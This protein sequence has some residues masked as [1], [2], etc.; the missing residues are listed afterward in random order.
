MVLAGIVINLL[1]SYLKGQI[2]RTVISTTTWWREK[3]VARQKAWEERIERL[4]K[5]EDARE[6]TKH[7]EIVQRLQSIHLLLLAMFMLILPL[8][9][10]ISNAPL[11]RVLRITIFGLSALIFFGSFL[12]FR[13]AATTRN[14]LREALTRN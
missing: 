7:L 3:S 1:S 10:S 4:R 12:V 6:F 2:D 14:A 11:P 8:F 9:V 5:S 13:G